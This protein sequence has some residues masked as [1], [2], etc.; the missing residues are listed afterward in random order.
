MLANLMLMRE[1]HEGAIDTYKQLLDKQPD[2]FNAL[3]QL[4][5][6]LRRTGKLPDVPKY[7]EN[8]EKNCAR[9]STAG[10]AFNKGLYYRYAGE[11]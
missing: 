7:L 11:P 10:L 5:E 9:S 8:A 3:A 6:L 1:Q 4:I 2:N